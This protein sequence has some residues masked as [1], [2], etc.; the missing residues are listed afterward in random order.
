MPECFLKPCGEEDFIG[1]VVKKVKIIS[2]QDITD[3]AL[4]VV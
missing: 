4:T 3:I 1:V 2:T